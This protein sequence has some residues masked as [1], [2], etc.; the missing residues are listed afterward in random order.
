MIIS[1]TT[2][3]KNPDRQPGTL[4]NRGTDPAESIDIKRV[5]PGK[6]FASDTFR[7]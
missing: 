3:M 7:L 5:I 4:E 6:E 1:Q 2:K